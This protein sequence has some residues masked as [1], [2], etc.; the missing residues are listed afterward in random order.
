MTK[1]Q[2]SRRGGSPRRAP[3]RPDSGDA[4]FP[5]PNGGP[6]RAPDGISEQLGEQFVACA[7]TGESMGYAEHPVELEPPD[8]GGPF[9]ETTDAEEFAADAE[10]PNTE[11]AEAAAFPTTQSES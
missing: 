3:H 4:F 7:T 9:I 6:A 11:D 8:D 1:K 2:P 5:D 10:P